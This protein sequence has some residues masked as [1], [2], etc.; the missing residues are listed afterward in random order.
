MNIFA[1]ET[2]SPLCAEV[3]VGN[4]KICLYFISMGKCKK[5]VTP[6]FVFLALTQVC[7]QWSYVFLAL[8]PRYNFY[9]VMAQVFIIHCSQKKGIWSSYVFNTAAADDLGHQQPW[10][11]N[12]PGSLLT[13]K[14]PSYCYRDFH[15]KPE[16]VVRLSRFKI[17]IPIPCKMVSFIVNKGPGGHFKNTYRLLNLRALKLTTL[18]KNCIFLWMGKIFCVEF[19]RYP[20]K[21]H[22]KY[23]THTLKDLYFIHRWKFKSS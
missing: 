13:K 23:L 3:F 9:N 2:F 7:E 5:D 10:H 1:C 18:Y 15:Y 16:M 12:R 21:F 19:Q 17:G 20:L 22:T 4:M 14:T 6:M 8:T 11:C